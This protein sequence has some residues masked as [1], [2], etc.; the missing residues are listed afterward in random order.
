MKTFWIFFA[1]IAAASVALVAKWWKTLT[2]QWISKPTRALFSTSRSSIAATTI[3]TIAFVI[4]TFRNVVL[5]NVYSTTLVQ[6][7]VYM[8]YNGKW[9]C[10]NAF[11]CNSTYTLS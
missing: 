3:V 6:Y 1:I 5:V 10:N 9:C 4:N 11:H 7:N 8:E 2:Q